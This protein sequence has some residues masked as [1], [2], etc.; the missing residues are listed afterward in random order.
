[1]GPPPGWLRAPPWGSRLPG[2]EAHGAV[3]LRVEGPLPL[4]QCL[5][6]PLR[7]FYRQVAR[8]A[9]R[10]DLCFCPGALPGLPPTPGGSPLTASAPRRNTLGRMRVSALHVS[11]LQEGCPPP[12]HPTPGDSLWVSQ[13]VEWKVAEEELEGQPMTSGSCCGRGRAAGAGAWVTPCLG[14]ASTV[15]QDPP[16]AVCSLHVYCCCVQVRT[17][18]TSSSVPGRWYPCEEWLLGLCAVV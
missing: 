18:T 16:G 3:A 13:H 4:Q 12:P 10:G 7:G 6:M 14:P 8:S 11:C 15:E 17:R 5:Q 9:P 1:M 2:S